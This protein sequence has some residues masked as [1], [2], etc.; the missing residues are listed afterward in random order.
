LSFLL[1]T[2][3]VSELRKALPDLAI[4]RWRADAAGKKAHVSTLVIGEVRLGIEQLRRRG[5]DSQADLFEAWLTR[6]TDEFG[7]RVLPVSAAVADRWGRLSAGRPLPV[8][9]ALMGATA[10]EHDLIFVTRDVASLAGTGVRLLNPW[11]A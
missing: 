1:D 11:Q 10:M 2:N 9:D 5:D 6:L 3:V 4:A 8:V 7:D